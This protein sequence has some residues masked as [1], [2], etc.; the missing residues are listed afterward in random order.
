MGA[1]GDYSAYAWYRTSITSTAA[2]PTHFIPASIRDRMIVF[3]D[4]QRLPAAD[5]TNH[6]AILNLTPGK[7]T[8]AILAAH[9][10]RSKLF[11]VS[12]PIDKVDAKGL[13]GPVLMSDSPK[14]PVTPWQ[15]LPVTTA[16]PDTTT[17]PVANNPGWQPVSLGTDVFNHKGGWAWYQSVIPA[18]VTA[19]PGDDESIHFD[20]VDD[21]GT[22]FCNGKLVGSH[23]GWNSGFDVDLKSAWLPGQQNVITV[24]D[25]NV[26]GAGGISGEVNLTIVP[27]GAALQGWKMRGGIG[28]PMAV[29]GWEAL[30]PASDPAPPAFFLAHFTDTPAVGAGPYPILRV[31]L[32]GMSAG[33]VWL[34]GHNLGRFPE[35]I[36]VD[37]LYL[38]ECWINNGDNKLTIFDEDGKQPIGVNLYVETAASRYDYTLSN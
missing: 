19:N 24:L 7:H 20:S 8:L 34:N 35:K 29:D 22:I 21:N 9:Y 28:D 13:G 15:S 3:V 25:Q 4:G 11:G 1:D 17:T 23:E 14:I 5:V 33:F 30:S 38:P 27:A 18:T 36:P 37:G 2:A 10:G 26:D 32:G 31:H 6:D 16:K 12:G